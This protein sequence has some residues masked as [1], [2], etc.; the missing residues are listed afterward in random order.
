MLTYVTQASI[1]DCV[2][3]L[4]ET[5]K[6]GG[7]SNRII[8]TSMLPGLSSMA[9]P[10]HVIYEVENSDLDSALIELRALV[11]SQMSQDDGITAKCKTQRIAHISAID[12]ALSNTVRH[13]ICRHCTLLNLKVDGHA[14]GDRGRCEDTLEVFHRSR[15][16]STF[17]AQ[18]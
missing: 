12:Q 4:A 10:S 17:T 14:F 7:L 15:Q 3:S 6:C 11:L 8:L 13:I 5:C 9:E 2:A 16:M 18:A 1:Q